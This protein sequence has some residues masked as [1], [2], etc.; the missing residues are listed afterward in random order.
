[1]SP[2]YNAYRATCG[3]QLHQGLPQVICDNE[4]ATPVAGDNIGGMRR[5]MSPIG[6]VFAK[7]R[8]I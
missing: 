8:S 4:L 5:T 1:M 7:I 3:A 2:L 6:G